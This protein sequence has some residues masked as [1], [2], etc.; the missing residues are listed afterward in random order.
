MARQVRSTEL[1]FHLDVL[2]EKKADN[3]WEA[4]C[5]QLDLIAEGTTAQVAFNHVLNAIDVQI[6]TCI[7]NN[8]LGNLYFPAPKEVWDRLAYARGAIESCK[9]DR[10][11]RPLPAGVN[12]YDGME[13]DR[14]C[15]A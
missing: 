7:E 5:L 9:Y 3:E 4:H 11:I 13:V 2:V 15:Y 6:R 8:N 14:F 1:K 10:K 12:N